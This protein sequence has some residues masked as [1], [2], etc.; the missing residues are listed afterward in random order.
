VSDKISLNRWHPSRRDVL[1]AG[2]IG[3]L[4]LAL[5]ACGSD[6]GNGATEGANGAENGD[7]AAENVHLVYSTWAADEELEVTERLIDEFTD[8]NPHITVEIQTAA[9][10]DYS[11]WVQTRLAGNNEP[12]VMFMSELW[13]RGFA[14]L[15]ALADL[16]PHVEQD[17]GY[18]IG[19]FNDVALGTGYFN[20]TLYW[21]SYGLDLSV[22]FYNRTAF[23]ELGLDYPDDNWTWDDLRAAANALTVSQGGGT[24]YGLF[25]QNNYGS[26]WNWIRGNGGQVLTPDLARSD[27]SNPKTIEGLQFFR[28]MIL[29]DGCIPP[30]DVQEDL[31]SATM[32]LSGQVAMGMYGHFLIPRLESDAEF[33]WG[34]A[35]L[36]Q[37]PETRNSFVSGAGFTMSARTEHPEESWALISHMNGEYGQ[38]EI[39]KM[40][41]TTPARN[42]LFETEEWSSVEANEAFV[43]QTEHLVPL[44]VT[45]KW[46]EYFG[47]ITTELDSVYRGNAE[48]ADATAS[49]DTQVDNILAS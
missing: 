3:G 24:R 32:F 47:V 29:E 44:P 22:L 4:G 26:G 2:G 1:R 8:A 35:M 6:D 19:D 30:V 9:F 28:D 42:S 48:I 37:G 7:V 16:G 10:G 34:C 27:M 13:Y 11:T 41:V 15:G 14:D 39:M 21:T 49:I 45:P 17:P 46:N 12:D 18:D 31:G 36:P 43:K 23:D 33:E 40:G 25:S 38:G 20:D 5:G